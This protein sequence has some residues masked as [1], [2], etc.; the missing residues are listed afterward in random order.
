MAATNGHVA[1]EPGAAASA[2]AATAAAP[3]EKPKSQASD[4]EKARRRAESQKKL[5]LMQKLDP[6]V[7]LRVA[8]GEITLADALRE[9]GIDPAELEA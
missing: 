4:E 1:P 7:K 8:K 3:I 2:T 5:A 9:A 6:A